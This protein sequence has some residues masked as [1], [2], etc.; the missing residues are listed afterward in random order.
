MR[1][2]PPPPPPDTLFPTLLVY[3][4]AHVGIARHELGSKKHEGAIEHRRGGGGGRGEF[5]PPGGKILWRRKGGVVMLE[6]AGERRNLKFNSNDDSDDL[7]VSEDGWH[8]KIDPQQ[9][10]T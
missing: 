5:C 4:R 1:P 9:I 10:C 2:P 8:Q 6:W 7:S 3:A